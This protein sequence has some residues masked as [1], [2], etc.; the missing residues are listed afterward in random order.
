MYIL[1]I[2]IK[3]KKNTNNIF[4]KFVFLILAIVYDI[5]SINI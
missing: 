4:K 1:I 2:N 5:I 3:I